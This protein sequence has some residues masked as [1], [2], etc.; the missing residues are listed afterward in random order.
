MRVMIIDEGDEVASRDFIFC[1]DSSPFS[2][3]F[4]FA[5]GRLFQDEDKL[6]PNEVRS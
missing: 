4:F 3:F 2:L 5:F 6:F 1:N